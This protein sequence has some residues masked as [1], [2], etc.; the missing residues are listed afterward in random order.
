MRKEILLL[1]AA[2]LVALGGGLY[3]ALVREER[4]V[5][6]GTAHDAKGVR[7]IDLFLPDSNGRIQREPR[8]II[9]SELLEDDIRRAVD[10]L[11]A[12]G[13]S[14]VRPLPAATRLINVFFDGTG[15]VALNFN[16][17]LRSDHPGGSEA[18]IA[19]V[20]C[21]VSTVGTNFPGVDQVRILIEGETVATLAGHVSLDR[22]LRV[23]DYR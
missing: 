1:A 9:G 14:G 4:T 13:N 18:E 23:A 8:E 7:T 11:V 21:L 16:E 6:D 19:T 15:E 2:V 10:E 5:V 3:L 20:R 17:H 22:P 12:G